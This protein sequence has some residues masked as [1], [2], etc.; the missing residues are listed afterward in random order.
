MTP[1]PLDLG[2]IDLKPGSHTARTSA[3]LHELSE[4]GTEDLIR[5]E[6]MLAA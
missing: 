5:L 4:T 1:T 2:V 6:V 3:C